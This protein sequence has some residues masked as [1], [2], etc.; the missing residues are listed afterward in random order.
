MVKVLRIIKNVLA[1]LIP[2]IRKE[3]LIE[4]SIILILETIVAI[5]IV[6]LTRV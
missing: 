1:A 3:K 6:I 4:D 2:I 5:L